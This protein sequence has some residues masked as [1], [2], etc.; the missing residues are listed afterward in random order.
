VIARR[1][2]IAAL[3][4][5]G[6]ARAQPRELAVGPGRAFA[7]LAAAIAAARPGDTLLVEA[8]TYADDI[9]EI[10]IPLTIRARGGLARLQATRPPPNGKAILVI[11]A[12][13]SLEGL[14]FAGATSASLNG[15][16]IR[17]EGGRLMI[18]RCRFQG[19]QM[20]LLAADAAQGSIEIVESEFGATTQ[21]TSLSH[22]LYVNRIEQ[23]TVRDSLFHNAITGHQIKSRAR[24]TRITGSRIFDGDGMG[25]Y[26]IDLPNGGAAEIADC[27]LEQGP[28][29]RSPSMINFGGESEPF[30]G[31]SL[32]IAGCTFLNR[33]PW[34]NARLLT[35]RTAIRASLAGNRVFGLPLAQLA[36]G[37]AE[38][39]DTEP[40]A[41]APRLDMTPP[42]R[43]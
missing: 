35:N 19:N 42:W 24:R 13:V 30:P 43:G 1:V 40:L 22:S 10:R 15:A 38:A 18:R 21:T 34:S 28:R 32:R 39:R 2:L 26:N 4:A 23:L 11:N 12:D 3:A 6:I 27:V 31:S 33:L 25:A 8:G 16:G 14:D 17:Y 36:N 5:P 41:A 37:P 20:N 7:T 9:A 29:T